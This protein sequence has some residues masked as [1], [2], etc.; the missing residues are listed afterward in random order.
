MSN[1]TAVGNTVII[2][3]THEEKVTEGGLVVPVNAQKLPSEGLVVF[4][5]PGKL[6]QNG[7]TF[8]TNTIKAGDTVVFDKDRSKGI[9]IDEVEYIW[10]DADHLLAVK[11]E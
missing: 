3:L 6:N 7:D 10:C 11:G 2:K 5:G 8:I 1:V 4:S 9:I